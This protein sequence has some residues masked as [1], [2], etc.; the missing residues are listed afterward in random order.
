MEFKNS[1]LMLIATVGTF[2]LLYLLMFWAIPKDNAQ[3][4]LA[5]VGP[6]IGFFFGSS[7]NKSRPV[8][9]RDT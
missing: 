4:L 5:I 2:L 8:D 6:T 1:M 3:V 9:R 7:I